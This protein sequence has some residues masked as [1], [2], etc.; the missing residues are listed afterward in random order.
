MTGT[1]S[2]GEWVGVSLR[3]VLESGGHQARCRQRS[4]RWNIL[5]D[6][7]DSRTDRS[8][9]HQL[10]DI[11][12]V[13]ICGVICGTDSRVRVEMF[14]KSKEERFCTFLEL[15]DL[16]GLLSIGKPGGGRWGQT[17]SCPMTSFPG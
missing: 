3:D 1:A 7:E 15:P 11:I 9:R 12:T 17:L 16:A 13:A 8:E 4:G 2:N 5:A 14:G 6:L 10:L